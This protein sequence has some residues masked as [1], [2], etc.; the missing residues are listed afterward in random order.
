MRYRAFGEVSVAAG[1]D[2]HEFSER[3][4]AVLALLLAAGSETVPRAKII[5][6]VWGDS[7]PKD[8][9]AALHT[10]VS[11]L[12]S[13]VGDD[14]SS[15][16]SGYSITAADFDV[17]RFEAAVSRARQTGRLSDY[18]EARS[19]WVGDPYPGCEDLPSV[20]IEIERLRGLRRLAHFEYLDRLV[21]SNEAARA[22]EEARL[23]TEA[24]PF[25]ERAVALLMRA[26]YASGRKPEALAAFRSYEQSLADSTGLEPSAEI[27]ELEVAILLD[28]IGRP[29]RTSRA[30]VRLDL[31]IG[32]VE[33]APG[34]QVAVGRS[35]TG[36][37]LFFHPGWL[38]K[39]DRFASGDD[40]RS[41]FLAELATR[42]ELITFDRF[43]TG[44]S[45]GN[46]E[47]LSFESHVAETIA[48]LEQTVDRPV[49]VLAPSGAGPICLTVAVRSPQLV[50]RLVLYGTFADGPATFPAPVVRSLMALFSGSWG[51]G[52]EL[53]ATLLFPAASVEHRDVWALAQREIAPKEVALGLLEDMYA[54]S[55][56]DVLDRIA[57]PCLIVHYTGDK[58]IPYAAAEDMARR[59]P[60]ARLVPIEGVSHY[61][62]PG[63]ESTV[64]DVI[65]RFL[66]ETDR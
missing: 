24:D 10:V 38:S 8:P 46:P 14:L 35:G 37:P 56:S 51:M 59:I 13:V 20:A 52:S 22:A 9:D 61:P 40:F 44:L 66:A 58:A 49:P 47:D 36:S 23:L 54:S 5:D 25:D 28:E 50:S 31:A 29:V 16:R 65:D 15:T 26:L 48:V 30:P 11:R 60:G 17:A 19:L 57:I 21:E 7:T 42:H 41:P 2:G 27:R 3:Q 18:E 62:P 6:E 64:A 12:R 39:L 43:G 45:A 33:R 55:A 1:D 34:E 4:A 32:Y 63:E 53:L